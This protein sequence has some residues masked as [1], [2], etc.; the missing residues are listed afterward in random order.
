VN[1]ARRNTAAFDTVRTIIDKA[2]GVDRATLARLERIAPN[3][4]AE[5]EGRY[6]LPRRITEMHKSGVKLIKRAKGL[7]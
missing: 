2:A 4:L 1:E 6:V 7:R 5:A 3:V